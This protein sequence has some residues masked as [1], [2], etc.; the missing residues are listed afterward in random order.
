MAISSTSHTISAA[1][2]L[3]VEVSD[4]G[5]EPIV[6]ILNHFNVFMPLVGYGLNCT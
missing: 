2:E 4:T 6:Y 5:Q 3:L 1:A